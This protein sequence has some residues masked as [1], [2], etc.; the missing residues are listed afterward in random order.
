MKCRNTNLGNW[1]RLVVRGI[2]WIIFPMLLFTCQSKESINENWQYIIE[3]EGRY[4]G[5][6]IPKSGN[7]PE[8]LKV[9]I[10]NNKMDQE[11]LG[12][13]IE[14][15][16]SYLFNP[17]IPLTPGLSY[18]IKHKSQIL[19]VVKIPDYTMTDPPKL[20]HI[21]PSTDTVPENL[22]KMY[23]EFSQPMSY[24]ASLENIYLLE[25]G[26]TVQSFLNLQNELWNK[27]HTLLTL[28]LD[29]GRIKRELV[30]NREQGNPLIKN[31]NYQL[32]ITS[33]WKDANGL[34]LGQ[35]YVKQFFVAD[36][37]EHSPNPTHWTIDYSTS[38]QT[39]SIQFHEKLDF[40]LLKESFE[41]FDI[42][43]NSLEGDI[44]ISNHESTLQFTP[45]TPLKYG[46]YMV[47]T[48]AILEDLAGNNLNRLF[49][50]EID[51]DIL[52]NNDAVYIHFTIKE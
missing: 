4:V 43:S 6:C 14:T 5:L 7:K 48:D 41:F 20:L 50:R 46:D 19:Q 40:A 9:F 11:I 1:N 16:S 45:V 38:Q 2:I 34:S 30:P 33:N 17:I 12:K 39:L 29:P 52:K 44:A 49:D 27:D 13:I 24:Q 47:K 42:D 25:E 51:H 15:D 26:D 21:Y 32:I 31:K 22:L 37:D 18:I 36:R 28:W 35:N 10:E 23:L 8:Q 3:K